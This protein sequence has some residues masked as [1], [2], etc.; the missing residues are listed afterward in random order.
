MKINKIYTVA[1]AC[2]FCAL[3]LFSPSEVR[4]V[5]VTLTLTGAGG[6]SSGPYCVYPYD[7]SVNNN[8]ANTSR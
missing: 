8:A 1:S 7:F 2:V 4:A 6:Q 3:L 5:S